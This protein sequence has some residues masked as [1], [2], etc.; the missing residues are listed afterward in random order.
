M[1]ADFSN[2]PPQPQT[3]KGLAIASLILGIV[4][5][6]T[7]GLLGVGAITAIV[8]GAIAYSR[9]KKEPAIFGGKGMAM[10]GI[11]TSVVSL[12]LIPV[13]GIL[14]AVAVPQL[15]KT[16]VTNRESAAIQTLRTI[17]NS[18]AMYQATKQRFGT[19]KELNEVGL[20]DLNYANGVPINGYV[21]TSARE[22]TQDKYCIQATRQSSSSASRDFNVDQDGAIRFLESRTPGPLA[23]GEGTPI[24]GPQ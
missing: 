14:A 20:I 21:Y 24:A 15:L 7:L 5:I 1:S 3:R 11:I 22:V 9:S 13:F 18:Q 10:A 17:H 23:C 6:P 2:I 19:L 12:L 8:L 4:S 16:H